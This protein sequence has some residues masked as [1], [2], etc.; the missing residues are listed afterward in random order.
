MNRLLLLLMILTGAAQAQDY[1]REEVTFSNGTIQLS[2][3]LSFPT[4]GTRP[5]PAVIL[6]SGSGAQDRDSNVFGFKI[7]SILSDFFNE[8]G[9]AVLRYD[10]RGAGMSTGKSVG[11]STSQELAEDAHQAFLYLQK[12]PAIDPKSIGML[13]H[14]E[15]GIIVPMVASK[16][17]VA[18]AILLA[19]YGVSGVELTN[20]QQAAVLRSS[21]MSEAYILAAGTMNRE[22]MRRMADGKTTPEQLA[23]FVKDEIKKIIPLLPDA[24]KAQLADPDAYATT[25]A[26]QVVAQQRS[27]WLR[28]YMAYDPLPVLQQVTCPTLLLFGELDT[29]VSAEQNATRMRDALVR[30]GNTHVTM[31]ILPKANHLFQQ[32]VTGSPQEYAAL[33]KEFV[34][35]LMP[36]IRAWLR[37][38]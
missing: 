35:E 29:Q 12:H 32:A 16:E 4:T 7:F 38:R 36:T 2:G 23:A 30:A 24:M 18:F 25:V 8:A 26:N 5:F 33:K 17:P 37:T 14:S 27:P 11:E 21:G 34:P 10:D 28:Y 6:V 19:G 20:V 15:G 3:T 13:G 31:T 9:Y 22:V 1:P